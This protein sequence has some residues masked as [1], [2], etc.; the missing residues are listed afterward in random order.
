MPGK[1]FPDGCKEERKGNKD[2]LIEKGMITNVQ[3]HFYVS[4][5]STSSALWLL[6]GQFMG[7]DSDRNWMCFDQSSG[8]SESLEELRHLM[9]DPLPGAKLRP[10]VPPREREPWDGPAAAPDKPW[11]TALA[12]VVDAE[13]STTTAPPTTT[14]RT[15]TPRTT[16]PQRV[17]R[18]PNAG[19]HV[20]LEIYSE[21]VLKWWPATA[22]TVA[23]K[24]FKAC[25]CWCIG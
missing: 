8:F 20:W 10:F 23:A 7:D 18:L 13:Q 16:T 6:F 5:L 4:G 12:P 2:G 25:V 3:F 24:S 1:V 17:K 15:T 22:K 11:W 21:G 14:R 19:E 9:P